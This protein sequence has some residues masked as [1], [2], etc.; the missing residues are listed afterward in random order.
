MS[1]G[2][3]ERGR[4][5][6]IIVEALVDYDGWMLDDDYEATP[7]LNRIMKRM[8]ERLEMSDPPVT[9]STA[10]ALRCQRCGSVG[11]TYVLC[12]GCHQP[13][14]GDAR[15]VFYPV[16]V[17]CEMPR[18]CLDHGRC[19]G[20]CSIVGH[21]DARIAKYDRLLGILIDALQMY[22][23]PSFYHAITIIGDRPTGG[24]DEDIS[25]VQ[26][27][28]YNRPMPGK[29]ARKALRDAEKIVTASPAEFGL[30]SLVL[31]QDQS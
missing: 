3:R 25:R 4:Y 13:L 16:P 27:S 20:H 22:A 1:D 10:Q 21:C 31:S 23:D 29:L 8:R 14:G 5:Y 15:E 7:V 6:D 12:S 9:G 26:G 30:A 11:D 17:L 24:F 28:D 19:V 18:T 2:I